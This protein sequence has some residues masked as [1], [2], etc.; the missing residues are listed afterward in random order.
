MFRDESN[1]VI[2]K[3]TASSQTGPKQPRTRLEKKPRKGSLSISSGDLSYPANSDG[4]DGPSHAPRATSKTYNNTTS[5]FGL[6]LKHHSS[7]IVG[8]RNNTQLNSH[9]LDSIESYSGSERTRVLH[10]LDYCW[11]QPHTFSH[12]LMLTYLRRQLL[13]PKLCLEGRGHCHGLDSP[14][15]P[16]LLP[17]FIGRACSP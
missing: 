3:A 7:V 13:R 15:C 16:G 1:K 10:C 2:Q 5:S 12:N 11:V 17:A 9:P 4:H 14:L 6:R 8:L